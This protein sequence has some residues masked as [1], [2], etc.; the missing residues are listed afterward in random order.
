M[1]SRISKS[2]NIKAEFINAFHYY[3]WP[4]QYVKALLWLEDKFKQS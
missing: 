3:L 1:W 4:N 2:N